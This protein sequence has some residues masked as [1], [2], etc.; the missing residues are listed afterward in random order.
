MAAMTTAT[1]VMCQDYTFIE[2]QLIA[3][4]LYATKTPHEH[5]ELKGQGLFSCFFTCQG[6][7]STGVGWRRWSAERPEKCGLG[8][9]SL[10]RSSSDG[11]VLWH[12]TASP[13]LT[14]AGQQ[15]PAR[16]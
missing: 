8:R 16:R 3:R 9:R 15:T 5:P 11:S 1:A 14:P 2:F 7:C 10:R 6:I 12:Q 4:D 13:A